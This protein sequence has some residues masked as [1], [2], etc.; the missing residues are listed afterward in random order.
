[1]NGYFYLDKI[2]TVLW[3]KDIPASNVNCNKSPQGLITDTC[4]KDGTQF[5]DRF[6]FYV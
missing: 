6:V 3:S 1:M 5:S 2:L 4:L